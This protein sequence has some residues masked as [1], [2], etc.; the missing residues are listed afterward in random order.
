MSAPTELRMSDHALQTRRQTTGIRRWNDNESTFG[1]PH[2]GSLGCGQ[3]KADFCVCPNGPLLRGHRCF[4]LGLHGRWRRTGRWRPGFA[5]SPASFSDGSARPESLGEYQ[6]R[7]FERGDV[8]CPD[9]AQSIVLMRPAAGARVPLPRATSGRRRTR[10]S[11][12]GEIP[13]KIP[14]LLVLCLLC[15]LPAAAQHRTV[16][17]AAAADVYIPGEAPQRA[18]SAGQPTRVRDASA[19]AGPSVRGFEAAGTP[20]RWQSARRGAKIGAVVG[21]VAG[22]VGFTVILRKADEEVDRSRTPCTPSTPCD[23]GGMN[24]ARAF[25]PVAYLIFAGVGA[26]GGALVGAG[27]GAAAGL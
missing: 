15:A 13:M 7:A 14:L 26:A 24:V 17:F 22:V 5:A 8:R 19:Y 18:F 11:P 9:S 27:V 4:R 23:R 3:R 16:P 21:A 1:G 12:K 20:D 10:R 2:L 6:T 25:L